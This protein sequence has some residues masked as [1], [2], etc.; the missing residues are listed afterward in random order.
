MKVHVIRDNSFPVEQYEQVMQLLQ[1]TAGL[2]SFVKQPSTTDVIEPEEI[3]ITVD[4]TLLVD[5]EG[6]LIKKENYTKIYEWEYFFHQCATYR[7]ASKISNDEFVILLSPKN[8]SY[9][10]LAAFSDNTL[11]V[12]VKTSEWGMYLKCDLVYP[13]AYTV[14]SQIL[15]KLYFFN[16]DRRENEGHS[17]AVGCISDFCKCKYEVIFKFRTA[18]VCEDCLSKMQK[19]GIL[20]EYFIQA[21][22]LF[23]KVRT[24][25]LFKQRLQFKVTQRNIHISLSTGRSKGITIRFNDINKEVRLNPKRSVLY[26]FFL[27]HPEGVILAEMKNCKYQKELRTLYGNLYN[28]TTK[29]KKKFKTKQDEDDFHENER[30]K[31]IESV[32][33]YFIGEDGRQQGPSSDFTNIRTEFRKILGDTVAKDYYIDDLPNCKENEKG[34]R[35]DRRCVSYDDNVREYILGKFQLKE[36]AVIG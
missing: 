30:Q 8:N 13:T 28:K 26:L 22:S 25:M 5:E 27:N 21:F 16:M 15:S 23:E 7:Q 35:L 24:E 3:L 17:P 33:S 2:I 34:I 31:N 6:D 4:G 12:F 14:M 1:A 18:D 20:P 10:Y 9:G 11:D 19:A 29:T 32:I 36:G